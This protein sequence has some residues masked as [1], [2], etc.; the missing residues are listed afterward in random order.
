MR[1]CRLSS[2]FIHCLAP[3]VTTHGAPSQSQVDCRSWNNRA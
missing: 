2:A 1:N 3:S